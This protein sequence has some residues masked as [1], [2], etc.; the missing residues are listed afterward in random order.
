ML[1]LSCLRAKENND[2]DN[3]RK[4]GMSQTT[5]TISGGHETRRY[6]KMELEIVCDYQTYPIL[7]CRTLYLPSKC[8]LGFVIPRPYSFNASAT[9]TPIYYKQS[10]HFVHCQLTVNNQR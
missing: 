8:E 9:E 5:F 4:D 7:V 1:P 10:I 2:H 3:E 6:Q